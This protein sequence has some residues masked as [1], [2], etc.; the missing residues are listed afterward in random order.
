VGKKIV[1]DYAEFTLEGSHYDIGQSI[2][3]N[4]N[5]YMENRLILVFRY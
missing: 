4:L 1:L 3:G 2:G 5:Q